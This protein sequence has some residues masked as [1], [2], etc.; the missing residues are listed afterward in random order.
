VSL[1]VAL[2]LAAAPGC[3]E[4]LA[5]ARLTDDE[6]IVARAPALVRELEE[7]GAG[8]TAARAA[9]AAAAG[10]AGEGR[11][12]AAA[13]NLFRGAL[14][15]HCAL[16]AAPAGPE[17][18]AADR[19]A[20]AEILARPELSQAR[21]DPW[22]IRRALVRMWDWLVE[23]LGTQEA[24]RYASL[25]RAL[26]LGAAAAALGLTLAAHRRRTGAARERGARARGAAPRA[27]GV[28]AS[29]E[30]A[31][32]ALRRGEAREAVRFALLA[33]LGALERAGRIPR[34]RA[35]TNE[36]VVRIAAGRPT[37]T[38]TATATPT[39]T[40]LALLARSFDRAVY[41]GLP[42]G[43]DEARTAVEQA[44]RIAAFAGGAA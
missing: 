34:G 27:P 41:G 26:F 33:A 18:T 42:V 8:P 15:R 17:A 36:E 32:E 23:L 44:R 4:A 35:L 30:R 9:A 2:A 3:P 12:R 6:A 22:A 40:D 29:A 13:A 37:A 31:E 24:E 7:A 16:A 43:V 21:L 14:V 19:A 38:A 10:T 5:A 11:S 20:L 39:A 28:D 1:V 25:G